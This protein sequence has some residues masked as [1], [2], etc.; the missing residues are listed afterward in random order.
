[1]IVRIK[2]ITISVCNNGTGIDINKVLCGPFKN[3]ICQPE[4]VIKQYKE[5]LVDKITKH[6]KKVCAEL[7]K[8]LKIAEEKKYLVFI[9]RCKPG[10]CH[11]DIIANEIVIALSNGNKFGIGPVK[12]RK[13]GSYVF[14][15]QE[16][17]E[18]SK[19]RI[20]QVASFKKLAANIPTK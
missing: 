3:L 5:W 6:D 11:G 20:K 19:E 1:M 7:N 9:C 10:R 4:E 14:V 17:S 12:K 13:S 16:M 15:Q 8:L 2:D 18:E